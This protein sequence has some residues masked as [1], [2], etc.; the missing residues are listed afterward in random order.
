MSLRDYVRHAP[1]CWFR[2]CTP[3]ESE[4]V[5]VEHPG[6]RRHR[7]TCGLDALLTDPPVTGQ[8]DIATPEAARSAARFVVSF[9]AKAKHTQ[10]VA[11]CPH[12]ALTFLGQWVLDLLGPEPVRTPPPGPADPPKRV[13]T[14]APTPHP[15]G[16]EE[17]ARLREDIATWRELSWE[18]GENP[19]FD[20]SRLVSAG[21]DLCET[22]AALTDTPTA[23]GQE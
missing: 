2:G 4:E 12:C 9:G 6:G 22:A 3:E 19:N 23:S 16:Q 7:C 17:I 15:P 8:E 5:A 10:A 14:T 20:W 13:Q 1:E 18:S 21:D 11:D